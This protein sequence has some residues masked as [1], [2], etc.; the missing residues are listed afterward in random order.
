MYGYIYPAMSKIIQA[1][2]RCI[3]SEQDKG[4]VVLMDNRFMSPLY[5][6]CFPWQKSMYVTKDLMGDIEGF[7]DSNDK[8]SLDI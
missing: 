8:D 1:A 3:R 6:Q 7:F 4:V 2:G 5:A